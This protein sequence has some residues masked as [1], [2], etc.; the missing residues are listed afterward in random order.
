M[1]K[2]SSAKYIDPKIAFRVIVSIVG[3]VVLGVFIAIFTLNLITKLSDSIKYTDVE[4]AA[5]EVTPFYTP[6]PTNCAKLDEE[7]S[8]PRLISIPK[9]G[10]KNNCLE[11]VGI[12]DDGTLGDP[13]NDVLANIGYL[14]NPSLSY[15]EPGISVYTC[16]TSFNPNK[17][18]ICDNLPQL[19]VDDSIIVELNSGQ[20]KTYQIKETKSVVLATVDMKEFVTAVIKGI[21]SLSIMTCTGEYNIQTGGASHRLLV[22]AALV[23]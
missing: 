19:V 17:S 8:T 2:K 1:K 9:I 21:E 11:V 3:I 16:H 18:A 14:F 5:V 10:I 12:A 4:T 7:E 23:D 13:Q 6:T 22:R 15:V 20:K